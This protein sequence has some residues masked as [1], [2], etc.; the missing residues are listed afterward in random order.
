M[1][2][3]Q[4]QVSQMDSALKQVDTLAYRKLSCC[5]RVFRGISHTA[6]IHLFII[7]SEADSSLT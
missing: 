2:L 1:K 3:L 7:I 5:L 4:V 6:L